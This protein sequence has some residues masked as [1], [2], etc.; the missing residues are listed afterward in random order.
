MNKVELIAACKQ[1][2]TKTEAAIAKAAKGNFDAQPADGGWSAGDNF[3]HIID[4]AHKLPD[5]LD[6]FVKLGELKSLQPGDEVGIKAFAVLNARMLPIEL[7]TAH[8]ILWMALQ[9]LTDKDLEKEVS[10]MGGTHKLGD[11]AQMLLMGHEVG[12]VEQALKAAGVA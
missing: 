7:N 2:W 8:G 6:E 10:I 1:Q 11:V 12:H 3:R 4:V 5:G 9:K